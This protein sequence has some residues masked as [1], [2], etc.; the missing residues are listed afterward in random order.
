MM[1]KE[2]ERPDLFIVRLRLTDA[3]L[4]SVEQ[5]NTHTGTEHDWSEPLIDDD[6]FGG[7]D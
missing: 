5:L 7:W 1:K 4:S 6:D 3:I 2:Y